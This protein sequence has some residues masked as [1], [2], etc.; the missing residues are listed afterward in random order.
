[1]SHSCWAAIADPELLKYATLHCDIVVKFGRFPHRNR[2]MGRDTTP[3]EWEFWAVEGSRGSALRIPSAS[4][5]DQ[6]GNSKTVVPGTLKMKS[7]PMIL[8]GVQH[9]GAN[10]FAINRST[11][12]RELSTVKE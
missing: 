8:A 1:V 5:R 10:P 12:A 2:A 4:R 3:A 9:P 11:R 7:S 6:R